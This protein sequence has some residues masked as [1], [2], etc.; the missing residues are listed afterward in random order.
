MLG[1]DFGAEIGGTIST[2]IPTY[3]WNAVATATLT[4]R[5]AA[6]EEVRAGQRPRERDVGFTPG[7]HSRIPRLTGFGGIP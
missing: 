2:T 7:C 5:S 4:P 6:A 1:Q 3:T